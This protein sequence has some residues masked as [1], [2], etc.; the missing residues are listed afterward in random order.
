MLKFLE[1]TLRFQEAAP[2]TQKICDEVKPDVEKETGKKYGVYSARWYRS[3]V[4]SGMNFLIK[5]HVGKSHYL[6]LIVYRNLSGEVKFKRVKEAEE[7]LE[8]F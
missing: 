4:V 3:Q 2:E 8:P 5:V 7:P 1:V 6:H